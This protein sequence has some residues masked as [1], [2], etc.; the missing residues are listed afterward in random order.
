VAARKFRPVYALVGVVGGA[1][2]AGL[3][4][5]ALSGLRSQERQPESAPAEATPAV[6]PSGS[7]FNIEPVRR[8]VGPDGVLATY[9][10]N[11]RRQ[12]G[13]YPV[14]LREIAARQ[15]GSE[16]GEWRGPFLNNPALL[17]DKWGRDYRYVS[18]GRH[19]AD[20]YDLWSVGA[21]GVDGTPDD[22]GNW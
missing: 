5:A 14:H 18:P 8:A 1:A 17:K 20:E 22:V 19:H 21:D 12:V 15:S 7:R 10:A 16:S 3:Y 9:L 6:S 2:L 4:W 13:R 11:Y